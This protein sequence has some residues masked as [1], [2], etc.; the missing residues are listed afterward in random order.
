MLGLMGLVLGVVCRLAVGVEL[1]CP[2]K[3]YE[4]QL[5]RMRVQGEVD[6]CA[7]L[8]FG[9]GLRI[10]DV[11]PVDGGHGCVFT[12]K[13]GVYVVV[14]LSSKGGKLEQLQRRVLIEG[15]PEP[16]P[17]PPGPLPG[18]VPPG[19]L[20]GPAFP[21][22]RY[23]LA[24]LSYEWL[25]LVRSE[26]ELVEKLAANFERTAN[27]IGGDGGGSASF[28]NREGALRA[29]RQWNGELLGKPGDARFD[30]WRPWMEA[31]TKELERLDG[32]GAVDWPEGVE[33][34]LRETS[35]G[36]RGGR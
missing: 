33:K 2:D 1:D 16:G 8:V 36:L 19:P 25:K 35:L 26:R 13:A 28:A 21:K 12:A 7:W 14:L 24:R 5:V 31:W 17:V 15:V 3:G 34:V 9:E 10:V 22:G 18:P 6:S 23:D 20:P 27:G 4:H 11:E 29:L 32:N 30:A